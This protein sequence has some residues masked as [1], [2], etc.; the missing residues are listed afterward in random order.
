MSNQSTTSCSL[1]KII[2]M[3][4]RIDIK[5]SSNLVNTM[6]V[7]TVLFKLEVEDQNKKVTK[8]EDD[9]EKKTKT[10]IFELNKETINTMLDGLEFV[11]NQLDSIK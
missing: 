5:S 2:D 3:D 10:V 8:D 1:P 6:N 11:K 7:P 9:D 4:W